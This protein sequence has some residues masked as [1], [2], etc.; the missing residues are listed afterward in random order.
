MFDFRRKFIFVLQIEK[1][2]L[3]KLW[4]KNIS[5]MQYSR[6]WTNGRQ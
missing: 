6:A 3:Q 4:R 2:T 5:T 1:K